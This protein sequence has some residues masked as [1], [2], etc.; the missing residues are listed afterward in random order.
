M[1]SSVYRVIN[2]EIPLINSCLEKISTSPFNDG[3]TRDAPKL[4]VALTL[5]R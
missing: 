4:L 1:T 5:L 3:H 2:D